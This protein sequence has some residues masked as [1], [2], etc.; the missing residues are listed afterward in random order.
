MPS[1]SVFLR[2][3]QHVV[4][5][6]GLLR[7]GDYFAEPRDEGRPPRL[8]LAASV[9]L[10]V[11]GEIPAAFLHD[12]AESLRLIHE[13]SDVMQILAQLSAAIPGVPPADR[14]DAEPDLVEHI[15]SWV[16][17]GDTLTHSG[18]PS[19]SEVIG[20]LERLAN[21]DLARPRRQDSPMAVGSAR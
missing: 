10:A 17:E 12:P 2:T 21:Q 6:Y 8:D 15:A 18:A 13:Q 16:V 7:K 20:L 9:Y 5:L 1:L 11:T 3:T 19:E 4:N 14:P